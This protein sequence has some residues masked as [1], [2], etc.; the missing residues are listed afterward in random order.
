MWGVLD[1]NILTVNITSIIV[2][3]LYIIGIKSMSGEDGSETAVGEEEVESNL[4]VKQ[5]GIRFALVSVGIITL[6]I[7]ITYITDSIATRLNLGAGL[8]GALFLG[9]ATSL[10]ELAST[11]ALFRMRN[12]NIAIGN[13][14]GSNIFNFLILAI[15]D[16]LYFGNGIYDYTD[17]KTVNLLV[18]GAIAMPVTLLMIKFKNKSMQIIAPI[19][20]I[21]CYAAFLIF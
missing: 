6:S 18:C 13:I 4:T 2:I 16:V 11:I 9:I 3:V 19:I 5:I 12:F 10:P 7:L 14:I 15:V 8:A 20:V 17:P 1:F 21:A